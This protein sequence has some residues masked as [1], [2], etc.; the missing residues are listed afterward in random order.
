M[1]GGERCRAVLGLGLGV[2]PCVRQR[3]GSSHLVSL[4]CAL[5][6]G[7]AVLGPS[8]SC[9]WGVRERLLLRGLCSGRASPEGLKGL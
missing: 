2:C 1:L 6:C 5:Q 9:G 4:A 7:W 8:G 3:W